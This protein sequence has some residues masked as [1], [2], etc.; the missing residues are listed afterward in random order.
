MLCQARLTDQRASSC[1]QPSR[2]S[3]RPN[4]DEDDCDSLVGWS[5]DGHLVIGIKVKPLQMTRQ[6]VA[7]ADLAPDD[8]SMQQCTPPACRV[9]VYV[10]A[11]QFAEV[12]N[13]MQGPAEQCEAN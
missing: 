13:G 3:A 5:C 11:K 10:D 6:M 4:A 2:L 8:Q 9:V 7:A 12:Q 1:C